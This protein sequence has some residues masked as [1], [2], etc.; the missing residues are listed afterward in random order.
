MCSSDLNKDNLNLQKVHV[1]IASGET[2]GII[3]GTGSSKSSFV[4]LIPRLY[5]VTN[6]CVKVGG[7]DVRDYEI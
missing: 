3:G 2:V 4:Q 7:M 5:D 6:G 1:A